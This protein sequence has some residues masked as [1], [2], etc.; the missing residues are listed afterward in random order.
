MLATQVGYGAICPEGLNV[1]HQPHGCVTLVKVQ[2]GR[3]GAA[4]SGVLEN[5][6]GAGSVGG[7]QKLAGTS[8][9]LIRLSEF[10]SVLSGDVWQAENMVAIADG[11]RSPV[12][13]VGSGEEAGYRKGGAGQ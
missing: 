7:A 3:E 6:F 1:W 10:T 5:E 8:D 11:R 2:R 12:W 9:Q 13:R 4:I